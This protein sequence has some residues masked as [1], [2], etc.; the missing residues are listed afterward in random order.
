[1]SSSCNLIILDQNNTTKQTKLIENY[2]VDIKTQNPDDGP[3]ITIK[4]LFNLQ[5]LNKSTYFL[6]EDNNNPTL[7]TFNATLKTFHPPILSQESMYVYNF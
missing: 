3:D 4:L 5:N 7:K 2:I 6:V 1:M